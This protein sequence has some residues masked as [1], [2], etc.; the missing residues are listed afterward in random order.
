MRFAA[1]CQERKSDGLDLEKAHSRFKK[2]KKSEE[3]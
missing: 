3:N 2:K 1:T